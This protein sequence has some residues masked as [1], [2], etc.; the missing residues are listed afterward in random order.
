[1]SNNSVDSQRNIGYNNN[2]DDEY[3]AIAGISNHEQVVDLS[4]QTPI[5]DTECRHET[6]IP[7]PKDTLEGAVY[8]GCANDK[9]PVG[10]YIQPN[11]KP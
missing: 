3:A 4:K 9:C 11:K 6:L 5:H 7:N 8:H 2:N 10:F 1:M